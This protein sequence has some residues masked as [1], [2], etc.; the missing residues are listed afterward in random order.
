MFAYAEIELCVFTRFQELSDAFTC[1]AGTEEIISFSEIKF[2]ECCGI[3]QHVA[4]KI[5]ILFLRRST[6]HGKAYM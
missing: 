6:W 3:M 1:L 2:V 4:R 5:S